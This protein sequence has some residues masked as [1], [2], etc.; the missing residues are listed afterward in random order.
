MLLKVAGVS[1]AFDPTKPPS[2]RVTPGSVT[3]GSEPVDLNKT[4]RLCT[5]EYLVKGK[6]GYDCL[7]GSQ[8]IVNGEDGPQL[9]TIIQNHFQSVSHL[10]GV[11]KF[12]YYHHQSIISRCER[13]RL[14]RQATIPEGEESGSGA[15]HEELNA[16]KDSESDGRRR[17]HK[18]RIA[19]SFARH[20]SIEDAERKEV[21][22]ALAPK[23]RQRIKNLGDGNV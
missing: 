18:A 15:D 8:M 14:S 2:D 1:F 22:V 7:A 9:S 3:V 13:R 12:K 21:K 19:L 6:D 16:A 17:W 11:S 4:Y 23:V 5:K 10:T 20:C